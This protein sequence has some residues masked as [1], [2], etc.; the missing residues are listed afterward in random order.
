MGR[1]KIDKKRKI[2]EDKKK[3]E[4]ELLSKRR[5]IDKI[6]IDI[7]EEEKKE[8][9]IERPDEIIGLIFF[10]IIPN[11]LLPLASFIFTLI[12]L[13]YLLVINNVLFFWYLISALFYIGTA[14]LTGL[15]S[16]WLYRLQKFS[17]YIAIGLSVLGLIIN[18]NM[19]FVLN[20]MVIIISIIS[21]ILNGICIYFLLFYQEI[22]G[23]LQ[24]KDY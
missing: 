12:L 8:N 23:A 13:F 4:K 22:R 21:I 24:I 11:I 3:A 10:L 5:K 18:I 7:E 15:T 1:S 2:M 19:L 6:T 14:T 9:E 16:Y 20:P 17:Y